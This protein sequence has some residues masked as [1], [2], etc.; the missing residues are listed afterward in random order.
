LGGS[1][2]RNLISPLIA[3]SLKS[4]I[5][6]ISVISP[7][8]IINYIPNNNVEVFPTQSA[9]GML[10]LF[11]SSNIVISGCGQTLHEL[12]LLGKPTIGICLDIDQEP[13]RD[14]Y[15]KKGFLSAKINWNDKNFEKNIL[16]EIEGLKNIDKR[17][18]IAK[19]APNLINK[20]GVYNIIDL[21]QRYD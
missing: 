14:F 12:A 8:E 15:L 18:T 11:I 2:F 16:T 10:N 13:N 4:G 6:K 21:I 7:Q 3:I 20:N 9:E 17:K 5:D 19:I 1:D